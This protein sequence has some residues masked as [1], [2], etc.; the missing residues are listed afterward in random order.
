MKPLA[1]VRI[2]TIILTFSS[3]AIITKTVTNMS[4]YIFLSAALYLMLIT[5]GI[6][7]GVMYVSY[8]LCRL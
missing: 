8:Y 5:L 1:R 7:I 4:K 6:W 2:Y 3:L